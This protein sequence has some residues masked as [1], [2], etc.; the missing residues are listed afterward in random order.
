[1]TSINPNKSNEF[2]GL[3]WPGKSE[4]FR[5]AFTPPGG[6]LEAVESQSVNF[7][8][9]ENLFIRGDNLEALK[10]LQ[11][12]FRGRVKMIYIDPP[13]NTGHDF[14][15]KD[16]YRGSNRIE[17]NDGEPFARNLAK[18]GRR[19]SDWLSM[20]YPRM[21]LAREFLTDDG[22]IFISI[23]DNEIHVLTLI[24]NE[25]F[26]EENFL[27]GMIRQTVKGG[28]GPASRIRTN[29]DYIL[30]YAGDIEKCRL[31]ARE[32]KGEPLDRTDEKGPYRKGRELNKWGADS[33]REDN[34]GMFF[35]IN[36]P[37]GEEVYPIRNDGS[38]GR[39]RWG[40]EK[41]AAAVSR[42]E[43]LFEPRGDGTYIVY[44]KIRSEKPRRQAHTSLMKG[45]GQNADGTDDL[46]KLFDGKCPLHFPKPV[47]LLRQL[48]EMGS[49]GKEDI[50]LDFFA[51]SGTTAQAVLEMNRED[52][53]QRKFILVQS[54]DPVPKKTLAGKMGFETISGLC[55]ERIRR[56]IKNLEEETDSNPRGEKWEKPGFNFLRIESD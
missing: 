20:M 34:P 27:A 18:G 14:V 44:E 3:T 56:A 8:H 7:N 36:G 2:F 21:I 4:A 47:S 30:T 11:G 39:W 41:L 16:R 12:G 13:Y 55:A 53:G 15:Y 43:V 50:I 9:T 38:E 46:K 19:H 22:V 25:I 40:K 51:G 6:R 10:L 5:A 45:V 32:L 42:G 49:S 54:P 26:G 33:R 1:M 35:P 23:D 31:G 37:G 24:M 29:H 48:L 17:G 52:G 28:T